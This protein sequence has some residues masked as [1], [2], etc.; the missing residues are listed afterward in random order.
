MKKFA[1]YKEVARRVARSANLMSI[2]P[3]SVV[4]GISGALYGD[5]VHVD[6]KDKYKYSL[7]GGIS[8]GLAGG[9]AGAFMSRRLINNP[10]IKKIIKEMAGSEAEHARAVKSIESKLSE[11]IPGAADTTFGEAF[12]G[13]LAAPKFIVNK[14]APDIDRVGEYLSHYR[15]DFIN[16]LHP[17]T[18]AQN[19]KMNEYTYLIGK[20]IGII[21]GKTVPFSGA[22]SLA[23]LALLQTKKKKRLKRR[24]NERN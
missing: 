16:N 2:I 24:L 1:N 14:K 19:R 9:L 20:K 3:S 22:A 11:K 15:P 12:D 4:G 7:A 6:P 8:G 10:T 5:A 18:R 23:T 21:T 13:I 17:A